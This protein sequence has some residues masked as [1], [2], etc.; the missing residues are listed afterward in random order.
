[1]LPKT[2]AIID[3]GRW[4]V[5]REVIGDLQSS[6]CHGR[7]VHVQKRSTRRHTPYLSVFG[8]SGREDMFPGI[9]IQFVGPVNS[10]I[11]V[12]SPQLM[13]RQYRDT[14]IAQALNV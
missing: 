6:I 1:M 4:N 10:A 12:I 8:C 2:L 13:F 3:D 5:R 14:A 11:K 7:T 9:Q